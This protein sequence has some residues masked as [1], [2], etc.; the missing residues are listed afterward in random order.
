MNKQLHPSIVNSF[1]ESE[2]KLLC[3][4][5][6]IDY[7]ILPGENK[8]DKVMELILYCRRREILEQLVD[9]IILERPFLSTLKIP[10]DQTVHHTSQEHIKLL[11]PLRE[12][13]EKIAGQLQKGRNIEDAEIWNERQLEERKNE[14]LSWRRYTSELLS[15]IANRNLSSYFSIPPAL[16]AIASKPPRLGHKISQLHRQLNAS[17]GKLQAIYDILELYDPEKATK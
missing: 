17:I 1:V 10:N 7:E 9:E 3:F 16:G 4:K 13:Q 11:I 5:L 6:D 8:S 2:L 14:F 15:R 12:A